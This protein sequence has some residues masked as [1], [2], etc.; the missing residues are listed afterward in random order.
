MDVTGCSPQGR[1]EL[2]TTEA[3]EHE[4]NNLREKTKDNASMEGQDAVGGS[5]WWLSENRTSEAM[6]N[7]KSKGEDIQEGLERRRK[8]Q[9]EGLRPVLGTDTAQEKPTP[10]GNSELV[11]LP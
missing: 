1:K 10:G 2:D 4:R 5:I 11:W 3:T 6:R 8:P 9:D 7:L